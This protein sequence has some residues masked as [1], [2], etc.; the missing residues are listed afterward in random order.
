MQP[1]PLSKRVLRWTQT[2]STRRRIT[3]W[4]RRSLRAGRQDEAQQELQQHQAS[5]E[6]GG[7]PASTATF[8]SSKYTQ[9][10]VP[11][12]LEQPDKEGVRIHFVDASQGDP[13]RWRTEF[14][15]SDRS[16]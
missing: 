14:L 4:A 16:D 1:S 5:L 12:R 6:A 7:R 9:A 10:R 15:R 13:G 2:I 3:C 11:F 8:E